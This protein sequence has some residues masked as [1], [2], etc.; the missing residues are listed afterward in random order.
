MT[1]SS[2]LIFFN[3]IL[4]PYFLSL[5][6]EILNLKADDPGVLDALD[7][8]TNEFN[9]T[10]NNFHRL[11]STKVKDAIVQVKTLFGSIQ[12]HRCY[13]IANFAFLSYTKQRT[14]YS[15]LRIFV[16]E[17]RSMLNSITETFEGES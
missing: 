15:L 8:A 14:V 16:Q 17:V 6:G 2:K 7:F 12:I 5:K 10:A 4:V 9:A 13:L 11:M 3:V 1:L